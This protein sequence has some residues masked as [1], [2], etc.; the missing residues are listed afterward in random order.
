M[1]ISMKCKHL[2]L[3]F[4]ITLT[5]LIPPVY[6]NQ[7]DAAKWMQQQQTDGPLIP[8][9]PNRF[10]YGYPWIL[11]GIKTQS[12]IFYDEA[13]L[14]Q[15]R[16]VVST[17]KNGVGEQKNS[18]QTPRGWHRICDKIG[19]EAPTRTIISR[20]EVTP[21]LYTEELHQAY[22]NKDWILSRIM[23]LCGMEPGFNRGGDVDSYERFI[24]IHGAGDHT[25]W[26][27]PASLGCVRMKNED[28]V[29]LFRMAPLGTDVYID[30]NA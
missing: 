6:A 18:Y 20:R 11:V 5:T 2:F 24:Y 17:A 27:T 10:N 8:T 13:G 7:A 16:Y 19:G 3:I 29:E 23:W 25:P 30:E 26:G 21:W 4:I 1:L 28:V 12:L 22:P 9:H 14:E 15:K